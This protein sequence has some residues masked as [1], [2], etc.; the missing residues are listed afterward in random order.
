MLR[1]DRLDRPPVPAGTHLHELPV[2]LVATGVDDPA[3]LRVLDVPA[4]VLQP[5]PA[6]AG[7]DRAPVRRRRQPLDARHRV[8]LARVV[9]VRIVDIRV[10]R[11]VDRN[12]DALVRHRSREIA[13]AL[14][15]VARRVRKA[16]EPVGLTDTLHAALQAVAGAAALELWFAEAADRDDAEPHRQR[17]E[18]QR[19]ESR[20]GFGG[21]R[22]GCRHEFT[23]GQKR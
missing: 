7:R 5:A 16:A 6:T 13:V 23:A 3:V 21:E 20:G 12:T 14:A 2:A 18:K 8:A 22:R 15:G 19:P 17:D 11:R 4:P 10:D 9:D 1:V